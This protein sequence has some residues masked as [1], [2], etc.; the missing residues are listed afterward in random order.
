M[1]DLT[2]MSS[3]ILGLLT[4]VT[5]TYCLM[6]RRETLAEGGAGMYRT[7]FEELHKEH[8]AGLSVLKSCADTANQSATGTMGVAGAMTASMAEVLMAHGNVVNRD[9]GQQALD[10]VKALLDRQDQ[11]ARQP[12]MDSMRVVAEEEARAA[13]Q[14]GLVDP[15]AVIEHRPKVVLRETLN[16]TAI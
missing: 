9:Y 7:A 2:P 1:F 12:I 6:R 15:E 8:Q 5:L 10:L 14:A 16:P 4:G 13:L 3:L 11:R